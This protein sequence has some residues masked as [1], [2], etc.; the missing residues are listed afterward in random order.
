[1]YTENINLSMAE[2][3]SITSEYFRIPANVE[4][5]ARYKTRTDTITDPKHKSYPVIGR[6][7]VN[8]TA[9]SAQLFMYNI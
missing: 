7:S 8:V 5:T 3:D 4:I 1:M 6:E 9:A 2:S